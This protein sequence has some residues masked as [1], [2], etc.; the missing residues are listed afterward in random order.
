MMRRK[1]RNS[2]SKKT[3]RSEKDKSL[4]YLGMISHLPNLGYSTNIR[5]EN[6]R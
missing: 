1:A 5:S 4:V 6:L 2:K 3:K